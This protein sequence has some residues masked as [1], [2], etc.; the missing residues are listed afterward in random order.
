[1]EEICTLNALIGDSD[2]FAPLRIVSEEMSIFQNIL[3][4]VNLIKLQIENGNLHLL[5]LLCMTKI[6][7]TFDR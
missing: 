7:L 3:D 2:K 1:M 6:Q 5:I 4:Y